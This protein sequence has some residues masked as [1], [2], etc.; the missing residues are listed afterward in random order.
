MSEPAGLLFALLGFD[1]ILWGPS[2]PRER[3]ILEPIEQKDLLKSTA[4]RLPLCQG[5]G[6]KC[7]KRL[8]L[9]EMDVSRLCVEYKPGIP[10]I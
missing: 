5:E 6:G 1:N 3:E 7:G 2:A 10:K 4:T 8:N 9:F